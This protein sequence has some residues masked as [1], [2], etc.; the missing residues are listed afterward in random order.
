MYLIVLFVGHFSN[1]NQCLLSHARSLKY[2]R[3]SV[4]F[5]G[6]GTGSGERVGR[7]A[8]EL[9]AGKGGGDGG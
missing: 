9:R 4:R 5:P 2:E 8:R 7:G 1:T 6:R 3:C